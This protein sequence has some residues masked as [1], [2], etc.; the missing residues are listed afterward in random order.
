MGSRWHGWCALVGTCLACHGTHWASMG[1]RCLL[2]LFLLLKRLSVISIVIAYPIM[3]LPCTLRWSS[4]QLCSL[5]KLILLNHTGRWML[6]SFQFLSGDFYRY[7]SFFWLTKLSNYLGLTDHDYVRRISWCF[8]VLYLEAV[9]LVS[10]RL[11][12]GLILGNN[13]YFK[14][15]ETKMFWT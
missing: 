7:Q 6:L 11:F 2:Q 5:V 8:M 12:C 10:C 13:L 1:S 15:S 9:L 3:H 14:A 4:F